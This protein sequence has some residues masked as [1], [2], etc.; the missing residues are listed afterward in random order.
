[1]A[2]SLEIEGAP[3]AGAVDWSPD[4]RWLVAGGRDERGA[5]LFKIPLDGQPPLR[6]VDGAAVNPIW[7][8]DGRLIVYA[9]PFVDG[10]VPLLGVRPDGTRVPLP[11]VRVREGGY[12]FLP[13]GTGIVFLSQIRSINF[14]VLDLATGRQHAL[15]R[16]SD[17]GRLHT[18]DITPDGKRIVF[19][20]IQENS[21]L[22][23]IDR[24]Q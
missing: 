15:T 6:L 11:A 16:L 22:V 4:G 9:G 14:S 7:S 18:F 19:D 3:G 17:H 12:R 23:L 13:D 10:Q 20:R 2:S 24:A 1:M 5:G 8:P 21:D